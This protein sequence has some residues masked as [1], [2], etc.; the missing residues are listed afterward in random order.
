MS[1]DAST[2]NPSVEEE[3]F[4]ELF[5]AYAEQMTP[6][7]RVGEKVEA[8]IIAIG[9]EAVFVDTGCKIDGFVIKNELLDEDGQ[10]PHQVG[11]RLTLYVVSHTDTG[12]QLS[13]ALAGSGNLQTLRTALSEG[14]PVEGKVTAPCKGG[15]QVS[16]MGRRA[17]CP[18]SQIDQRYV[19]KPEDYVGQSFRFLILR[20]EQGGRNIVVSRRELLDREQAKAREAFLGQLQSGAVV[21]GRVTRL[22]GFGA[23]VELF[24]G[25]EGLVHISELSWSRVKQPQDI[26]RP[27]QMVSVKILGIQ[28]REKKKEKRI[29]L[30]L[31]QV[32][33]DP[34][35]RVPELFQAGQT[36]EG[37]VTSLTR[38]GA[39]MEIAPGIEGLVHIS[40]MSYRKRVIKPEEIVRRGDTAQAVIKEIDTDKRRI[41]LS[42]K[43][44]EGDPWADVSTR[45]SLGQAVDGTLEKRESFGLF[46]ALEPGITGLLPASKMR[47]ADQ[48]EGF[49][50]LKPGD[51][52]AVTIG[53]IDQ[54]GRR[55]TL[56]PRSEGGEGSWQGFSGSADAG[57]G[58]LGEKLQQA[59][60]EKEDG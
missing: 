13:K 3:D 5:E 18:I 60:Q 6:D 37:T 53:E 58:S 28:D 47:A 40:E 57:F 21:E 15:F 30:S 49:D 23:F 29:A 10:L 1:D 19:E 31:K 33:G 9:E 32:E 46:V 50:Q 55:I 45:Y 12:I 41:S 56:L 39:F 22:T 43:D 27:S 24:P 59:L 44:A 7:L 54:V 42:I 35:D 36:V 14:I 26:L 16:L 51:T 11:D 52:V 34:W 20:L 17:F 38:Y 48:P 4:A 2:M 25:V 8:P